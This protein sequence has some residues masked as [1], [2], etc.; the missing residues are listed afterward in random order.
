MLGLVVQLGLILGET[1]VPGKVCNS[2]LGEEIGKGYHPFT[3]LA[4][5]EEGHLR[6]HSGEY[7]PSA[8][9]TVGS[10]RCPPYSRLKWETIVL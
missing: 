5:K 8:E 4:G 7:S 2:V 1:W 6:I 3:K 10:I 9:G